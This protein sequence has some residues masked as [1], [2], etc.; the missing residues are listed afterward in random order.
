MIEKGI[1]DREEI[2]NKI[3]KTYKNRYFMFIKNNDT[4]KIDK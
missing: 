3:K 1:N 2:Q 4:N